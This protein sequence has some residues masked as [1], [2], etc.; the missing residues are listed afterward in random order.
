MRTSN[1]ALR[2]GLGSLSIVIRTLEQ[3]NCSQRMIGASIGT[4]CTGCFSFALISMLSIVLSKRSSLPRITP[5][6]SSQEHLTICLS[7]MTLWSEALTAMWS[8]FSEAAPLFN[9]SP[10]PFFLFQMQKKLDPPDHVKQ[11]INFG[12]A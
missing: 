4:K 5:K 8:P 11:E 3:L 12:V 6:D 9:L 2:W 7:F 10:A 1:F